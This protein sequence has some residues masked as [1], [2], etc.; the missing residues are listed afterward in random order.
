MDNL[1]KNMFL[2]PFNVLYCL[3]PKLTLKILFRLEV[4][5]PLNLNLPKNI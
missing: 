2:K 5:Y 4:G 1:K 3:S